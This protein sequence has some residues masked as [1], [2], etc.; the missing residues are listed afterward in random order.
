MLNSRKG[1]KMN[2]VIQYHSNGA[3]KVIDALVQ[4][5]EDKE[6]LHDA[7]YILG[8]NDLEVN[9]EH[10]RRYV[11]ALETASMQDKTIL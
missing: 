2:N 4:L 1:K 9:I 5:T 8:Q 6:K 3:Y 11:A 7:S 10:L